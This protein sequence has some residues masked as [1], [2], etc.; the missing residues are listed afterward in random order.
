MAHKS[1]HALHREYRVL[2][3]IQKYN[4]SLPPSSSC[5][6]PV[7]KPIAYCTD[8]D[9]VGAEFYI[10]EYI[11]GRIFIDP[12]LPGMT[13]VE[14]ALAYRDAIRV[15]ANIHSIPYSN[16]EIG[17][18]TFG[19]K[20]NYVKRQIKRLSSVAEL[21]SKT[22]GPIEGIEDITS[23]LW[24]ACDYCPDH[25]SLIHGDFKMDNLIFHKTEP[26]V[27]G[28]L[29][30]ELSTVGDPMCDLANLCMMYFMPGFKEGFG[31]AG[32]G[33]IPLEGTGIPKRK[34][35]LKL[36][37]HLL[38]GPIR[39]FCPCKGLDEK[40]ILAWR[41]FYLTFL[42]FKNCVIIH[43]V[44]QRASLG[45]A[46]SAMA[47]KVAVLLPTIVNMTTEIWEDEPPP[48]PLRVSNMMKHSSPTS[49]L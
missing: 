33:R 15:L 48:V 41:G 44:K 8:K 37:T 29:D 49:K 11:Q 13:S 6:V 40:Q 28:V 20:G 12:T 17:L 30:W 16:A 22:I 45:V 2:E 5:S 19:R 1:A 34:E 39:L 14:R 42:F 4:G 38:L 3:S 43:G 23:K 35:L 46:S 9:I 36:Y 7:P 24:N 25:V 21:Q 27:I 31:V 10:M 47:K 26:R 32:L 18:E